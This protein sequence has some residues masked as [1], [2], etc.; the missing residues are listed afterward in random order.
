MSY[1]PSN[2]VLWS[3]DRCTAMRGALVHTPL[4]DN[5]GKVLRRALRAERLTARQV[6][7]PARPR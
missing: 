7:A 6:P 3:T 1:I 5:A 2:A 4:R